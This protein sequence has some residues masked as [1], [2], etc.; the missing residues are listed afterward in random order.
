MTRKTATSVGRHC[1]VRW[2][3]LVRAS[4]AHLRMDPH[5]ATVSSQALNA[6]QRQARRLTNDEYVRRSGRRIIVLRLRR[7]GAAE[8]SSQTRL[9]GGACW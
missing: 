1:N 2:M 5:N 6:L 9:A 8:G 7:D 4:V 3:R